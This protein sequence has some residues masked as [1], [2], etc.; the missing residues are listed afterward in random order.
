MNKNLPTEY[1]SGF[2]NKI[3]SFFSNLFSKKTKNED[4][5]PEVNKIEVTEV[6]EVKEELKKNT[7]EVSTEYF[8]DMNKEQF[9]SQLEDN[10]DLLNNLSIEQLEKLNVYYDD[11]IAE[12]E[13]KLK[14]VS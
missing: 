5:I 1:K 9:I 4:Y 8:K 2:I 10:P 7:N 13:E 14:K 3:R 6:T 12:Y 11:I